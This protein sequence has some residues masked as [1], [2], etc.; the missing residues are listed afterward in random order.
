MPRVNGNRGTVAYVASND[1]MKRPRKR[2]LNRVPA[3]T[4]IA[5]NSEPPASCMIVV[6]TIPYDLGDCNADVHVTG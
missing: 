2:T 6:R 5:F 4:E 3:I 1:G